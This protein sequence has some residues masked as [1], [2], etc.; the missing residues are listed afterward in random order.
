MQNRIHAALLTWAA[1]LPSVIATA[2]HPQPISA[3]SGEVA[4]YDCQFGPVPGRESV[5]LLLMTRAGEVQRV[6]VTPY[7]ISGIDHADLQVGKTGDVSGKLVI[8]HEPRR[9]NRTLVPKLSSRMPLQLKLTVADGQVTGTFAGQWPH[10]KSL[11]RRVDIA[12]KVTGVVRDEATLRKQQ[13]TPGSVWPSWLGPNQNFS[14][15]PL[16]ASIIDALSQARLAWASQWV[17]PTESGSQRY[18]ACVGAPPCAG[19][20]SPLYADGRIYQF[21][22]QAS[23]EAVQQT[24]LDKVLAGEKGD[25][26]REKMQAIGW[27]E[28][29]LRRRWAIHADEELMCLD[30]ATG[31]TL[32][33]V[34]WPGEGINLY[35]HKCSLT[36]H[37]G[38][39]ADGNVYVFGGLGIIRC[40]DAKTGAVRWSRKLPGYHDT[41]QAFLAKCLETKNVWAPTRSFCHGLNIAGDVLLA[42]DGIGECGVVGIDAQTGDVRWH[43]KDRILGK[44]ATPMSWTHNGK[45]YVIAGN[46][47]GQITAVH[48]D[49]GEVAWQYSE[50]G[51]NE[52]QM[53]LIGDLL[54]GN[55]T[56]REK[57]EEMPLPKDEGVHSAPGANVGQVVCWR[58]SSSGLKELWTSPAEW[59]APKNS[60]LGTVCQLEEQLF[61][62]FRGGFSY[63]LV[64]VNILDR[65]VSLIDAARPENDSRDSRS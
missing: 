6:V 8:G 48:A 63:H 45:T 12:G 25:D 1:L 24:H 2:D 15:N 33:T 16:D 23:G 55:K 3:P 51:D 49:S 28:D 18:V 34:T 43:V 11:D 4:W 52:Y 19:G 31:K 60:P 56:S 36:N 7:G 38:V 32:W 30:A 17:G 41:M 64:D 42:P 21:R 40:V 20:A 29:D 53:L 10:E 9:M 35:D 46:S 62:C 57:R 39:I 47:S 22:Y 65:S 54:I 59:G 50:A 13:G 37:T 61:V 44:C 58:I 14:T 5:Q 27:T 26:T